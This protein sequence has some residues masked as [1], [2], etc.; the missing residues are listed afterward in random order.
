MAIGAGQA[1]PVIQPN[2]VMAL[3]ETKGKD[4]HSTGR[5]PKHVCF[6]CGKEFKRAHNLKIH[7]RL[8]TGDKPFACPFP[9]CGK[10]FRWKSSIVSHINWHR[11]KRGDVLPGDMPIQRITKQGT[12]SAM[13]RN[14]LLN[15]SLSHP[16]Q[17]TLDFG[18][19]N[20]GGPKEGTTLNWQELSDANND[21]FVKDPTDYDVGASL[22]HIVREH[23]F[24][25]CGYKNNSTE[26]AR[27]SPYV[28]SNTTTTATPSIRSSSNEDS[29]PLLDIG[30]I[31]SLFPSE[32]TSTD[33]TA[34]NESNRWIDVKHQDQEDYYSDTNAFQ[35]PCGQFRG[36]FEDNVCLS[37]DPI[38]FLDGSPI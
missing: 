6:E 16:V 24:S 34:R 3:L 25:P 38:P 2:T 31:D 8:H 20:E 36:F 5:K 35:I 29:P 32:S 19:G 27:L 37:Y 33:F 18:K 22:N 14:E 17:R 28:S 10:E 7:G 23:P 26:E 30:D 4:V 9:T 12:M 21:A 13:P 1:T 15:S 11:T